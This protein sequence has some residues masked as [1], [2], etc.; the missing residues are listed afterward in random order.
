M[1][2]ME[3]RAG[4]RRLRQGMEYLKSDL[5]WPRPALSIQSMSGIELAI[6]LDMLD[7]GGEWEARPKARVRNCKGTSGRHETTI[8]MHPTVRPTRESLKM[9]VKSTEFAMRLETDPLF[10]T[11]TNTISLIV[12]S[13]AHGRD[14]SQVVRGG[15]RNE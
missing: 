6:Y 2:S 7:M 5:R 15:W 8:K 11:S 14:R 1:A 10:R 12:L 4:V 13:A 9:A 3:L